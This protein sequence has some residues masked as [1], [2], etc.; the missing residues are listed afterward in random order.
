MLSSDTLLI[1]CDAASTA[2]DDDM[3]SL[4]AMS[5]QVESVSLTTK[6]GV[7]WS[8]LAEVLEQDDAAIDADPINLAPKIIGSEFAVSVTTID[9]IT[10]TSKSCRDTGLDEDSVM[11]V[12]VHFLGRIEA[13]EKGIGKPSCDKFADAL[14][15]FRKRTSC[16][17]LKDMHLE[18]RKTLPKTGICYHCKERKERTLLM[19]CS[20]CRITQYCSRECQIADWSRH[21]VYCDEWIVLVEQQGATNN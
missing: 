20:R 6:R 14:K 5:F 7:Q 4:D 10:I 18:A 1:G 3:A 8:D 2:I 15:F 19:V 11:P 9:G 12:L 21:K 13:G 17:C 16:S